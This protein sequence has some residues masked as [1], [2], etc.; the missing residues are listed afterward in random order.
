MRRDHNDLSIFDKSFF[1]VFEFFHVL[2]L[3][4]GS[5]QGSVILFVEPVKQIE[6]L[7]IGH[8]R[9]YGGIIN[10]CFFKVLGEFGAAI[11]LNKVFLIQEK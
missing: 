11:F 6:M 1:K 9:H 4:D 7:V 2:E 5:T 8:A 3:Y 10:F